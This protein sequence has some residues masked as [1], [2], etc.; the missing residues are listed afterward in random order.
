MN[1]A[2][3]LYDSY[4]ETE[5][6]I[7]TLLFKRE[8]LFTISSD[9]DIVVC[10]AGK[11]ILIDKK[12]SDLSPKDIDVLIIPGGG[13]HEIKEDILLLI[14]ACEENGAI[15][16]GICGGVDYMVRAGVLTGRRYTG[17]YEPD[18]KY[19]YL[20]SDGTLTYSMYESDNKMVSAKAEAYLEFALELYHAA[21][22]KID[23][24]DG[25]LEWFK[26]PFCWNHQ[27]HGCT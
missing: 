27:K 15:I 13:L 16:G 9:Q 2:L 22:F 24:V 11:K 14:K 5:I 20:P 10:Q 12:V 21:G 8:N 4:F 1:V 25:F 19:D 3:Y 7:A 6:G 18:E 17:Y 23:S 26:S